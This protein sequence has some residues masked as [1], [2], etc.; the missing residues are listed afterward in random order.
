MKNSVRMRVRRGVAV[1]IVFLKDTSGR[2]TQSDARKMPTAGNELDFEIK[3]DTRLALDERLR[4][5]T[6]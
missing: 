1:E 2:A 3:D 4:T 5:G 6:R